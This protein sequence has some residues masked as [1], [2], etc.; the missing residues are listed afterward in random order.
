MT[1]FA[2][3]FGLY[4]P[5]QIAL[6]QQAGYRSAVTTREGIDNP[7]RWNPLELRRIK[8]SGKDNWLA[9]VLRMRGGRRG[10]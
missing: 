6:V 1:S 7:Q 10:C 4:R 8:I 5:A 9:F 2:Y 3:P